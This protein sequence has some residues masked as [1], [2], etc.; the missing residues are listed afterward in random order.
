[1][2]KQT[3]TRFLFGVVVDKLGAVGSGLQDDL[4]LAERRRVERRRCEER[5]AE[6][7]GDARVCAEEAVD[8]V[9][10][11]QRRRVRAVDLLQDGQQL[12]DEGELAKEPNVGA[13]S[14]GTLKK[15]FTELTI[16]QKIKAALF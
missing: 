3:R 2:R 16:H 8:D 11:R 1:M 10:Q 6:D 4:P 12:L 13:A 15:H 14:L 7:V 9:E 5:E